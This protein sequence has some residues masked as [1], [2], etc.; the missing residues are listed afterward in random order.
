MTIDAIPNH[1][2][3]LVTT[4]VISTIYKGI[5]TILTAISRHAERRR[6]DAE[7]TTM[8]PNVLRDIGVGQS[9]MMAVLYTSR[10]ERLQWDAQQAMH[11]PHN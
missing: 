9:D 8:D 2:H 6:A 7:L 4:P 1:N 11:T 5:A 10:R 3:T